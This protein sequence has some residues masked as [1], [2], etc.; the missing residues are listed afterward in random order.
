MSERRCRG[1]SAK[2]SLVNT[3]GSGDGC[4]VSINVELPLLCSLP[5]AIILMRWAID[6]SMLSLTM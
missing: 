5:K 2:V 6:I 1:G 3:S 4:N